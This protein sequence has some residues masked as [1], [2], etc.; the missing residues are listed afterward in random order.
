MLIMIEKKKK[1]K[2]ILMKLQMTGM[3]EKGE[4]PSNKCVHFTLGLVQIVIIVM[5][6]IIFLDIDAIVVDMKNQATQTWFCLI[7]VENIAN[8]KDMK[9]ALI[10]DVIFYA[11]LEVVLL[12]QLKCLFHVSVERN[13]KEFNVKILKNINLIARIHV[14]SF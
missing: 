6:K 13:N 8:K 14:V 3:K 4:K 2:M 7:L 5:Q 1:S 9:H 12:V 10:L 11:I